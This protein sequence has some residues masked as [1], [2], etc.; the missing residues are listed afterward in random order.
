MVGDYG[1]T[2]R[3]RRGV[4]AAAFGAVAVTAT[5][6]GVLEFHLIQLKHAANQA[7]AAQ[8]DVAGP[9][10]P[11]LNATQFVQRGLTAPQAFAYNDLVIGR[12]VGH[13]SCGAAGDD[14]GRS[15][16][17]HEVCE[18]TGPVVL[19][20]KSPKGEFFFEPGVGQ[21]ATVAMSHG[22]PHCVMGSN[23]TISG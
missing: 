13:A 1:A 20:V 12:K 6:V 17:T 16:W 21:P 9:P 3:R 4:A 7:G 23:F 2:M 15:L 18:F 22:V 8:W 19:R 14:H 5:I 10:C 11:S